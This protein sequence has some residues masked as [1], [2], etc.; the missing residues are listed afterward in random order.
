MKQLRSTHSSTEEHCHCFWPVGRYR[1]PT[2]APNNPSPNSLWRPGPRWLRD[3]NMPDHC[4]EALECNFAGAQI[5]HHVLTD[6][7]SRSRRFA[8]QHAS[9]RS[10]SSG[11][12][13]APQR[14]SQLR[15]FQRF[16]LAGML[17]V[18]RLVSPAVLGAVVHVCRD[19]ST[20]KSCVTRLMSSVSLD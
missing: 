9:D 2:P 7:C 20:R 15:I 18:R 14:V 5:S 3:C 1:R 17:T 4:H 16:N 11:C 13:F 6:L 10:K 12:S 19:T 8:A